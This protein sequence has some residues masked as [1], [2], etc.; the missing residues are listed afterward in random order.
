MTTDELVQEVRDLLDVNAVGLYE[1]IWILRGMD[2]IETSDAM[3]EQATD[4]LRCLLAE[5][6]TRLVL[7]RWPSPDILGTYDPFDVGPDTWAD[8]A[9]EPYVAITTIDDVETDAA[10]G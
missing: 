10:N 7:L 6:Q 1:F 8:I 4:A 9:E 5:G 2:S 3:R